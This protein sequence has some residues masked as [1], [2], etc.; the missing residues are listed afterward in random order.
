[1][2]IISICVFILMSFFSSKGIYSQSDFKIKKNDFFQLN[3][4][5][6]GKSIVFN[7]MGLVCWTSGKTL[8][9]IYTSSIKFFAISDLDSVKLENLQLFLKDTKVLH[10]DS[11][12]VDLLYNPELQ[13]YTISNA[14]PLLISIIS[15]S[16][17][18][19][20]IRWEQGNFEVLTELLNL[21]NDL[22]P[23][24]DREFFSVKRSFQSWP[25][26]NYEKD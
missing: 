24:N 3:I 2:K 14:S 17:D 11:V 15:P 19:Y 26:N 8:D 5:R 22:I 25:L 13:T 10:K 9:G 20:L 4:G 23:I 21:V 6:P 7:T 16:W 12:Y 1:M 18:M